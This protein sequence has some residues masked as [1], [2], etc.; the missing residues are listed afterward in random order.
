MAERRKSLDPKDDKTNAKGQYL[1]N[2]KDDLETAQLWGSSEF[3][4]LDSSF[5]V[6]SSASYLAEPHPLLKKSSHLYDTV[7]IVV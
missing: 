4:W 6:G 2:I 3:A 7:F 5:L 1:L